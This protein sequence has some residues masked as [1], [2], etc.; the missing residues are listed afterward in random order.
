MLPHRSSDFE[1]LFH[2]TE[3]KA[4]KL[5]S[6][7]NPVYL[8]TCSGPGLQEAAVRNFANERLLACINGAYSELWYQIALSN[9]KQVDRLDFDWGEPVQPEPL[10]SALRDKPYEAV[11]IVHNENSTGVESPLQE[12]ASA[13]LQTRPETLIVVDAVSSLG[14]VRIEMDEWGIDFIL[15]SSEFCL[16]VPPGLALASASERA[17]R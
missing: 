8:A 13:A 16:A 17:L 11:L 10:M 12:L 1:A 3:E 2:R 9:G 14:G 5:F 15:A 6:T 4:R 7:H